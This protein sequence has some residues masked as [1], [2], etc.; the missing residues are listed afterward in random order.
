MT[1]TTQ[2][3]WIT[4]NFTGR[5]AWESSFDLMT[6]V[7]LSTVANSV[8]VLPTLY[9]IAK[10]L[11]NS[12]RVAGPHDSFKC[13]VS[14]STSFGW[15]LL[16]WACLRCTSHNERVDSDKLLSWYKILRNSVLV[17]S[18]SKSYN[19]EDQKETRSWEGD[20]IVLYIENKISGCAITNWLLK[21]FFNLT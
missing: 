9:S 13:L 19:T 14:C 1:G 3:N 7:H 20:I 6:S 2:K 17:L 16:R 12:W 8:F 10:H 5:Y 21:V 4:Y 11:A 18:Y 15:Q